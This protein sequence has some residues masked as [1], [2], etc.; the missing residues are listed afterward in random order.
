MPARQSH[1]S[2]YDLLA[3]A[4]PLM[5]WKDCDVADVRAVNSVGECSSHPY[6][7]VA[8]IDETRE[9]AVR[10]RRLEVG[11][12]LISKRCGTIQRGEFVPAE[13]ID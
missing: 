7:R 9:H 3:Q 2:G 13:L 5:T 1:K 4:H 10:E 11:W 8:L 6:K 12:V